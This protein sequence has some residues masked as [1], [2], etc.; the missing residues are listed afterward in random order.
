MRPY[1]LWEGWKT[2]NKRDMRGGYPLA[3]PFLVSVGATV[4]ALRNVAAPQVCIRQSG[5]CLKI[6]CLRRF[7]PVQVERQNTTI[8]CHNPIVG[9][10]YG[11]A[12]V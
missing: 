7:S 8:G 1:G 4:S 9:R 10:R 12:R 2:G 6:D 11:S 5:L 3:L